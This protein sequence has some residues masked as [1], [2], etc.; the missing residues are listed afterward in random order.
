MLRRRS[1]TTLGSLAAAV[2]VTAMAPASAQ[3]VHPIP[4]AYVGHTEKG[5][6]VRFGHQK[7]PSLVYNFAVI[8]HDHRTVYFSEADVRHGHFVHSHGNAENHV[9]V[10]GHWT[11]DG[12]VTGRITIF[13]H[14]IK[15]HAHHRT[16]D[17]RR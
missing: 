16:P 14:S 7:Q 11:R 8:G 6:E 9:A 5:Q 13:D 3:A 2:V 1:R 4:G 15:F 12:S 10:H 17:H